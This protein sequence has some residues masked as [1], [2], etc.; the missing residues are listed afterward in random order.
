M[1]RGLMS[2]HSLKCRVQEPPLSLSPEIVIP[3]ASRPLQVAS[4]QSSVLFRWSFCLRVSGAVAPSAPHECGVSQRDRS[5]LSAKPLYWQGP[6]DAVKQFFV[7]PAPLR[8]SV[9]GWRSP[10]RFSR[11]YFSFFSGKDL[12]LVVAI[13]SSSF[14]VMDLAMFFEAP[15][16]RELGISPRFEARAAPAA[17][18]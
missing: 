2:W 14:S 17:F 6:N 5:S 13:S 10:S 3:S 12:R 16:K 7:Q 8:R 9:S 15:C 11:N 1:S 18:C 4:L